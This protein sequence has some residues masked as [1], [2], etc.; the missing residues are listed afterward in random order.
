MLSFRL[1][2]DNVISLA[3]VNIF[4]SSNPFLERLY[5]LIADKRRSIFSIAFSMEA[6][7]RIIPTFSHMILF[8]SSLMVV[9]VEVFRGEDDLFFSIS[10]FISDFLYLFPGFGLTFLA[11]LA[12]STPALAPKTRASNNE[13]LARR[14]APWTPVHATSPDENRP[15]TEVLPRISVSIPPIIKCA[16]GLTGIRSFVISKPNLRQAANAVGNRSFNKLDFILVA[17][18]KT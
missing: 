4:S 8:R 12:A 7:D 9:R 11:Y 5:P 2:A 1:I 10:I 18:R 14:F 15:F 3:V 6:P 16:L 13:L 17:S